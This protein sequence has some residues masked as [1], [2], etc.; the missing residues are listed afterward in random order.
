M[1]T[2]QEFI[3]DLL[4]EAGFHPEHHKDMIQDIEPVLLRRIVTKL[5]I[6]LSPAQRDEAESML[7]KSDSEGFRHLCKQNIPNYEEYF[8]SI[9][10]EFE[11]EYLSNF[12]K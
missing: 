11:D 1:N 5:A 10:E 2:L 12:K 4:I 8:A 3:T 6:K 7:A 9:L